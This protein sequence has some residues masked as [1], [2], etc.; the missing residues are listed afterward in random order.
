MFE[1]IPDPAFPLQ[2]CFELR[3]TGR[4]HHYYKKIHMFVPR[5]R[6][7]TALRLLLCIILHSIQVSMGGLQN[8]LNMEILSSN[9]A[10]SSPSL[11]SR[12]DL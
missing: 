4:F 9:I 11:S 7:N 12:S 2:V 6:E 10:N 8:I 1:V 3:N 5:I